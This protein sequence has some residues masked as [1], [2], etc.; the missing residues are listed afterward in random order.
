[1]KRRILVVTVIAALIVA[2]AY[3]VA[4]PSY[5]EALRDYERMTRDSG[6]MD[7]Q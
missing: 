5:D 2:A 7:G 4:K 1:M 6:I 3:I